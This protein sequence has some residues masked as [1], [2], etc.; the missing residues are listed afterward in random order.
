MK[1]I[2]SVVLMLVCSFA[3]ISCTGAKIKYSDDYNTLYFNDNEYLLFNEWNSSYCD[4]TDG[5]WVEVASHPYLFLGR[6]AYYGN[7]E[8]P[9]VIITSRGSD[10][11]VK[12]GIELNK[13]S[14][15]FICGTED[16][17]TF[18][19]NEITTDNKIKYQ[20][21]NSD[22]IKVCDFYVAFEDYEF[23]YQYVSIYKKGDTHYFLIG[24]E[25]DYFYEITED[26]KN[27][28]YTYGLN[29]LEQ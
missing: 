6:T 1:K 14:K 8:N 11:Y 13:N 17:I 21:N 7:D 23:I 10:L 19:L 26:F 20:A 5:N 18:R 4:V 3:L 25:L 16:K 12:K 22:F 29:N 24:G 9:E 28:I 2:I 27:T 15:L